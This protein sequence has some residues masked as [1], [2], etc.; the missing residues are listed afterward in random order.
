MLYFSI[1]KCFVT[2]YNTYILCRN[3]I[4]S[5]SF[6]Q[7]FLDHFLQKF[8]DYFELLMITDGR[9][10]CWKRVYFVGRESRFFTISCNMYRKRVNSPL[11]AKIKFSSAYTNFPGRSFPTFSTH[12]HCCFTSVR[13]SKFFLSPCFQDMNRTKFHCTCTCFPFIQE[14]GGATGSEQH[15]SSSTNAVYHQLFR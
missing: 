8:C 1:E 2:Q 4:L 10:Q 11:S 14:Y 12:G 9:C 13:E 6:N 3:D 7:C 5:C 15:I